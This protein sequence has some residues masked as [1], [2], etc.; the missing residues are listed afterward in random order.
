MYPCPSSR[1]LILIANLSAEISVT[2]LNSCHVSA[3]NTTVRLF[4]PWSPAGSVVGALYHK[5]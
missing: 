1:T 2:Y 4:L 5:L 3:V